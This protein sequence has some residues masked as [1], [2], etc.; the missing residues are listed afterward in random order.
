MFSE[1]N[2]KIEGIIII[3]A[4]LAICLLPLSMPAG[5]IAYLIRFGLLAH[6]YTKL[7][8]GFDK[9]AGFLVGLILCSPVFLII[10]GFNED[11]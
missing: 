1:L 6:A 4:T 10:L 8:S 2:L 11:Y 9:G 7:S 3:L 5:I